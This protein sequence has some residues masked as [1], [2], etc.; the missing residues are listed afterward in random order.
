MLRNAFH[1]QE[2]FVR[3]PAAGG[4]PPVAGGPRA[5][6]PRSPWRQHKYLRGARTLRTHP[7]DL[8]PLT[9]CY[10]PHP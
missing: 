10:P 6:C 9:L 2:K 8:T 1:L 3:Q 7:S 4:G 5:G